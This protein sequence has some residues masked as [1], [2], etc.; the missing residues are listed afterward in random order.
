[1]ICHHLFS[2]EELGLS[3]IARYHL[4]GSSIVIRNRTDDAHCHRCLSAIQG[5]RISWPRSGASR[6]PSHDL[7][8]S[9]SR[10]QSSGWLVVA[11]LERQAFA[12]VIGTSAMPGRRASPRRCRTDCLRMPRR[13]ATPAASDILQSQVVHGRGSLPHGTLTVACA[14][15]R[16]LSMLV[17]RSCPEQAK[18]GR[19]IR[20]QSRR[21]FF[22][23]DRVTAIP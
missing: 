9:T 14:R 5:V 17:R 8:C 18:G 7:A 16:G 6:F 11:G 22:L 2:P 4:S 3:R 13:P 23:R 15:R 20:R 12:F 10:A 19:S 1:M 21:G